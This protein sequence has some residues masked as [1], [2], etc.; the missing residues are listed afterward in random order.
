MKVFLLNLI[1]YS[2][3]CLVEKSKT[4]ICF[5]DLEIFEKIIKEEGSD[6]SLHSGIDQKGNKI[7]VKSI[8]CVK[9]SEEKVNQEIKIWENYQ[10][11]ERPK[12]FPMFYGFFREEFSSKTRKNID[13]HLIFDNHTTT[14]RKIIQNLK[15]SKDFVPF[16]LSK[17]FH[18]AKT[19]IQT[20]VFLQTLKLCQRDIC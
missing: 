18:F 16:P 5:E 19:L 1:I 9:R 15:N 17:L 12:C 20:S 13:Y 4:N 7:T 3:F 2:K 11:N 10:N 14:L 6:W 8:S